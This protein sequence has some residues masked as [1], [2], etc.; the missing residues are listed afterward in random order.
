MISIIRAHSVEPMESR[1]WN[2]F[3]DE[4]SNTPVVNRIKRVIIVRNLNPENFEEEQENN[5]AKNYFSEKEID[6]IENE[7][8]EEV[9][10][11]PDEELED[12]EAFIDN[13]ESEIPKEVDEM[14]DE[15]VDEMS[16][17]EFGED[18]EFEDDELDDY[19]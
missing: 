19:L 7:L 17:E 5:M 18:E 6:D 3:E 2:A 4:N 9:D 13:V 12:I 15:E 8:P 11:M 10:E 14:S 1:I 16:D